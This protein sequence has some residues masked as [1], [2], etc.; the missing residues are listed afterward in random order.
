MFWWHFWKNLFPPTQ[1]VH[2]QNFPNCSFVIL[3]PQLWSEHF[4]SNEMFYSEGCQQL[5]TLLSLITLIAESGQFACLAQEVSNGRGRAEAPRSP[6]LPR[7]DK[8]KMWLCFGCSFETGNGDGLEIQGLIPALPLGFPWGLD[9]SPWAPQPTW[10]RSRGQLTSSLRGHINRSNIL[11][12]RSTSFFPK[13]II[14]A[15]GYNLFAQ[16]QVS[17]VIWE[18]WD[19]TASSAATSVDTEHLVHPASPTKIFKIPQIVWKGTK[20]VFGAYYKPQETG[21]P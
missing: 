1:V 3:I 15:Q 6:R 14:R 18:P 9:A 11:L 13:L 16:N 7:Q 12:P 20:H 2:L 19:C 5:K 21:K 17:N 10:N 8:S 4:D